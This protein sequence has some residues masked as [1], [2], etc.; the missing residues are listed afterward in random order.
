MGLRL[1][2]VIVNCHLE[3]LG[4]TR[5]DVGQGPD[6]SW[7]VMADPEGNELC[8]LAPYRPEVREQWRMQYESYARLD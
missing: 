3:A 8:V 1:Q 2:A 7:V 4:A 6:V 5:V